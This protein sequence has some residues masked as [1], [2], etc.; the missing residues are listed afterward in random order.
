M[1]DAPS[2]QATAP[3][4]QSTLVHV[5]LR[6]PSSKESGARCLRAASATDVTYCPT[7]SGASQSGFAFDHIFG[8]T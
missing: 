3:N 4:V 8:K 1:S 5:R 6:P 7:D 2:E